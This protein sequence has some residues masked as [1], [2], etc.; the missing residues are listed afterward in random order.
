MKILSFFE[1]NE[2]RWRVLNLKLKLNNDPLLFS[3]SP[4]LF[5]YDNKINILSMIRT[6]GN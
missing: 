5:N 1:S 4:A 6:S 2:I 3:L